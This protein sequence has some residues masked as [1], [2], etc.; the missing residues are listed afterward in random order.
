MSYANSSTFKI[1]RSPLGC[2]IE[3]N[4]YFRKDIFSSQV[5]RFYKIESESNRLC[6]IPALTI[7]NYL[8]S[9]RLDPK[10]SRSTIYENEELR[11]RTININAE[12]ERGKI[13][14][15]VIIEMKFFFK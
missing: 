10:S 4:F 5:R 3:T 1:N 12:V 6:V 8:F 7:P 11:L 2:I 13:T 9:Y 15:S 14:F